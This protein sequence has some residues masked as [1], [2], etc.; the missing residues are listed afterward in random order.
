MELVEIIVK[1]GYLKGN[2]DN[3]VFCSYLLQD[4]LLDSEKNLNT[5]N[6]KAII[7]ELQKSIN[8]TSLVLLIENDKGEFK[9]S[10]RTFNSN[11]DLNNICSNLVSVGK[12][13]KGGGHN[14][15]SGCTAIGSYSDI[16]EFIA[17]EILNY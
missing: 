15:S 1:R 7:S 13:V 9:G 6:H 8:Y 12:L 4:D 16:L 5:V 17:T 11:I 10:L 14:Y 3:F 2:P